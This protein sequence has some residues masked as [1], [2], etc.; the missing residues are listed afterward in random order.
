MRIQIFD[1]SG[2]RST[3][4][5]AMRDRIE[6][7]KQ[8][9]QTGEFTPRQELYLLGLLRRM[10][11]FQS[12]ARRIQHREQEFTLKADLFERKAADKLR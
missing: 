6:R 9:L 5:L 4:A 12:L 7:A 8:Y 11:V 1:D 3:Q 10:L 2:S